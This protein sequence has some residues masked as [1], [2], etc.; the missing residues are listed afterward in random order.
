MNE[1]I[2]W[3]AYSLDDGANVTLWTNV[4]EGTYTQYIYIPNYGNHKIVFYAK[5]QAGN[6]GKTE[7]IYFT[8]RCVQSGGGGRTIHLLT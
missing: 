4:P 2:L 8:N 3:I 7:T 1:S 5:D 6:T